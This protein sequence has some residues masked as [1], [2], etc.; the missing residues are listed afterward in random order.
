MS[1]STKSDTF[2]PSIGWRA[3]V[4]LVSAAMVLA[5]DHIT[6]MVVRNTIALTGESAPF[7]PGILSF[8]YV[9][10]IGAAF[11]LGEGHG[12]AFAAL[13]CVVTV[14]IAVYLARASVISRVEVLGLGLLAGGAIGNAIDRV[15][16]GYVVDFI[17]TDFVDFPVFN[18]ADI[19]ICIG[20]ALAFLGFMFWSPAAK[21]RGE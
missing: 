15:V 6:K 12:I 8:R 10:N 20:V 13:A 4:S 14:V 16:L 3:S 21:E 19:G 2:E 1:K 18:V 7:L 9:E 11:S 17:A 5:L